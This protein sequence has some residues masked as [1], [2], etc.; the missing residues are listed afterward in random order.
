MQMKS[1]L[2]FVILEAAALISLTFLTPSTLWSQSKNFESDSAS[3]PQAISWPVTKRGKHLTV[4]VNPDANMSLYNRIAVGKVSY[5]G[6]ARK[7]KA[8]DSEKLESL[9]RDSLS[10]DFAAVKLN[11]APSA[12]RTLTANINITNI[13]RTHPWINILTTAAIFVPVDFGKADTTAEIV[14]Q[15]TGQVVAQLEAEGC[16]QV[17]EVIPS[18]QPLGQSRRALKKAGRS[19]AKEVARMS[20]NGQASNTL[21]TAAV[22]TPIETGADR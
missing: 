17:Y 18:F 7:L 5:T 12:A 16:G 22:N 9:L 3:A 13:K 21:A 10:A 1:Q 4:H 19:I 14:D 15:Q 2:R 6:S 8:H 20:S 11:S